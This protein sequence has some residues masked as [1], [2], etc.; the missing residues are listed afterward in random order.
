M[1]ASPQRMRP[2]STVR[3]LLSPWYGCT[4]CGTSLILSGQPVIIVSAREQ[5]SGSSWM[6]AWNSIFLSGVM[7]TWLTVMSKRYLWSLEG[8][9]VR[10]GICNEHL[11]ARLILDGD[12]IVLE[13]KQHSL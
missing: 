3:M 13:L 6:R 7:C 2:S 11:F 9:I 10:E 8:C 5:R 4:A 1:R 12:I